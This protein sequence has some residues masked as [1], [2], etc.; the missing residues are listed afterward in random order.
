MQD[1]DAKQPWEATRRGIAETM[2]QIDGALPGSVVVRQMRCGK[3]GCACKADPPVLHGPYI[4]WTRTVHGK[5]VT[6]FLSEDQLVRY[7]PWFDNAR[8][9]K[10][11]IAMLQIASVHA[12]ERTEGWAT[13]AIDD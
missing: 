9:L 8:R 10:E 2:G 6:K 4:Q 12:V 13:P 3:P 5:T 1:T 7:Q 11:L